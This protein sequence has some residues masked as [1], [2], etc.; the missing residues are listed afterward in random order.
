MEYIRSNKVSNPKEIEA[1]EALEAI[2]EMLAKKE[3]QLADLA[4]ELD[5]VKADNEKLRAV[6]G[7]TAIQTT[8]EN[9]ITRPTAAKKVMIIDH[10]KMFRINLANILTANGYKVVG[11]IGIPDEA[12]VIETLL[13]KAPSIVTIDYQ[14]PGLNCLQIIKRIKSTAPDVKTVIISAELSLDAIYGLLKAGVNDFVTKPVQQSRL[15]SVLRS[16]YV[17]P[18]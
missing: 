6:I 1:L 8:E 10:V 4:D 16:L 3:A 14:M 12:A 15:V 13:L 7:A 11:E 9:E 17:P 5:Q 18:V 2:L